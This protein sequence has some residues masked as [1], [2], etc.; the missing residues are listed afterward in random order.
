MEDNSGETK[1]V[2][3]QHEVIER[4]Y[5]EYCHILCLNLDDPLK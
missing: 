4:F 5:A 1:A 3:H 2:G